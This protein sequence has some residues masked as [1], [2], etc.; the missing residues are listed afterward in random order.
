MILKWVKDNIGFKTVAFVV[1][2]AAIGGALLVHYNSYDAQLG[3]VQKA[4][5]ANLGCYA[6]KGVVIE[7][8]IEGRKAIHPTA[9][10][11][12]EITIDGIWN[13]RP[14]DPDI[15]LEI[16]QP[17]KG[18]GLSFSAQS[19]ANQA[20][21]RIAVAEAMN[22][23]TA[24]KRRI[25]SIRLECVGLAGTPEREEF[26]IRIVIEQKQDGLNDFSFTLEEK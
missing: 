19:R 18:G 20:K 22:R 26:R 12:R 10:P 23:Q 9:V 14:V 6:H 17:P 4:H 7:Q 3:R 8:L 15:P 2:G 25:R 5:I 1:V 16:I 24:E 11:E 21:F 13:L